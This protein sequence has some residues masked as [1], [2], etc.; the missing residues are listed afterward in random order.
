M[1]TSL[2]AGHS[3]GRTSA[4]SVESCAFTSWPG[5]SSAT[6]RA[7][8]PQRSETMPPKPRPSSSSPVLVL[9]AVLAPAC[10]SSS[11]SPAT[12][13]PVVTEQ[14]ATLLSAWVA[15]DGTTYLAGG[16]VGG[17]PGLL[18]RWDGRDVTTIATPGA[19]AFWWIH[20]TPD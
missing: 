13:A 7:P 16:V 9:V 3:T 12:F 4:D 1:T 5:D 6:P 2:P 8:V 19:H 15:P 11:S 18:L 17:G 20:G 10:S 14:E